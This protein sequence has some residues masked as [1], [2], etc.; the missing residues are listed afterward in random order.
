MVGPLETRLLRFLFKYKVTS[1]ATTGIAPAELLMGRRLQT[2]LDMLYPSVKDRVCKNQHSSVGQRGGSVKKTPY[3]PGDRVRYQNFGM[4]LSW[5]V[6]EVD[7]TLVRVRL[8][9]GRL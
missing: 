6:I 9:D 4:G 1:Q 8:E 2:P 7:G 5:V 3:V